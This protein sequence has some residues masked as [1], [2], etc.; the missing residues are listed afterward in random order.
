M[1][2]HSAARSST[3]VCLRIGALTVQQK[4]KQAERRGY[5]TSA[6]TS[7]AIGDTFSVSWSRTKSATH[8]VSITASGATVTTTGSTVKRRLCEDRHEWN[9]GGAYVEHD[10]SQNQ[11][12]TTNR[13]T[14]QRTAG[15]DYRVNYETDSPYS[16]EP[17]PR[18]PLRWRIQ[19]FF[20]HNP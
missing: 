5:R 2:R 6:S 11:G 1:F 18:T 15:H 3:R 17:E 13:T 9:F 8:A 16:T 20:F 19:V 12:G 14:S 10:S 4:R 7:H